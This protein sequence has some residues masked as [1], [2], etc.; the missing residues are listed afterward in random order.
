MKRLLLLFLLLISRSSYA[1]YSTPGTGRNW[2]LDSLVNNS[3]GNVTY[4]G[5][6]Y[7]VNDTITISQSDTLKII[8]NSNLKLASLVLININGT[9]KIQPPDSVKIT[10]QDTAQKFLGMRFDTLSSA[11]VLKKMIFEYGCAIKLVSTSFLIDSC[12]IRYNAVVGTFSSGAINLFRSDAVISNNKIYRNE[13]SAIIS[14][15]NIPSS[16]QIISNIIYE[17]DVSNGN[18]PQINLGAA[19]PTPLVIRNNT[20]RGLYD[21]SGGISF[22]PIGS[23]PNCIIENNIIKRNRYGIA[24]QNVNI[25]AYVIN[26]I[27]DS[28]NINPNAM[29]GGSGINLYGNSTINVIISRNKIRWNLWGVTIQITAKPN[30]GDLSNPDTSAHGWNYI[31]GNFH[32]DTTADLYNNTPDSIKAENNFWGTGNLD[33]IEAHIF[34]K[35]DNPALGFVDYIPIY[36][37]TAVNN[38]EF[39]VPTAYLLYNAYPNPFNPVTRIKFDIPSNVKRQ[40]SNVKLIV[41]DAL[42]REAATLV[43]ELIKPGRYE[44]YWNAANLS[45]GVYFYKLSAGTFSQTKK[46]I[47]IK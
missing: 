11:S 39:G 7:F 31:Y 12:I 25:N 9:L 40:T 36:I 20:I 21:M 45:S 19:N 29:T 15:A 33:T 22:L 32:N 2:N 17:N 14:G 13:R 23:I 24:F 4:S 35:P 6:V 5:G 1:D 8:N 44:I 37:P 10:A 16:P 28:N 34:H 38:N 18:Y 43:N 47:L 41:Y 26:N 30:L 3:S 42:G 27:I 46:L